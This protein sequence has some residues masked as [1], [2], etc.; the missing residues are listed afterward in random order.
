MNNKIQEWWLSLTSREQW[1]VAIMLVLAGLM[2]FKTL[3][4]QPIHTNYHQ[5]QASLNNKVALLQWVQ[6]HAEQVAAYSQHAK[7]SGEPSQE[8]ISQVI[9]TSASVNQIRVSKFQTEDH[10][11]LVWLDNTASAR[12]FVWLNALKQD[13]GVA[14]QRITINNS[15]EAG[16]VNV[17]LM[18][19]VE[20]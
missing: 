17:R 2:V 5:A 16:L 9:T 1:I 8:S 13:Y 10:H 6:Q 19:A 20:E 18:L 15:D 14:V 7:P 4:W 3:I 11:V 12:L